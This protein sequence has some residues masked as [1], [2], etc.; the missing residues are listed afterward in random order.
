MGPERLEAWQA[1]DDVARRLFRI[2]TAH[3]QPWASPAW[4]QAKRAALSVPLNVVEG[5]AWRPGPR[6]R[7]HLRVANASA[8]ETIFAIKF[9][10]DVGA[11]G[12]ESSRELT[13]AA[14]LSK[15]LVWALLRAES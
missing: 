1:A 5:Y 15:R 6:W 12:D 7:Y 9:L 2:S 8:L 4:D 14:R 13:E 3:W 11:L 10:R